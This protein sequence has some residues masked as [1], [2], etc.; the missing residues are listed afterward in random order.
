[1]NERVVNPLRLVLVGIGGCASLAQHAAA[2]G[3]GRVVTTSTSAPGSPWPWTER[4]SATNPMRSRGEGGA[5]NQ[6]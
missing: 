1:M 2:S 4:R 6:S 3:R 5:P